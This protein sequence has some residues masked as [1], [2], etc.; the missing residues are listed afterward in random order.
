MPVIPATK[1]AGI[2]GLWS[3]A[4]PGPKKEEKTGMKIYLK[5]S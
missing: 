2:G 1:E 4:S 3:E 5:N